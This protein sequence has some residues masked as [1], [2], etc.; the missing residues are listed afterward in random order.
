MTNIGVIILNYIEYGVT[1][2]CVKSFNKQT[3]SNVNV[4]FVIVDNDSPNESYDVLTKKFDK[5]PN[6]TVVK[7][8]E[9][10][11]FANGNNF[12]LREL[13]KIMKPDYV[14][15][16]NSDIILPQDGLYE[17]IIQCYDIYNFGVLG[18]SIYSI[19]GKFYQSPVR[20]LTTDRKKVKRLI[21][22]LFISLIK[23]KLKILFGIEKR[24]N[25]LEKWD[26]SYY[27]RVHDDLTL[28]GAFQ[29]MSKDYFKHY[30][31]AYDPGTFLYLEEDILKVRCSQQNLP[32]IYSPDF[33][34]QHLQSFST[35]SDKSNANKKAYF[36][37]K[38]M[39]KSMIRYKKVLKGE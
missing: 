20:N 3:R 26:N 36:R 13:H 5:I 10:L 31:D 21:F 4:R 28:H 12:G 15:F 1:I 34:V 9:N 19:Y 30:P 37:V 18:P 17:W 11:G 2:D 22:E 7:T 25:H 35:N 16:S 39:L 8:S 23:I 33:T 38:N 32:M 24:S 6:V 14:I 29:V 27:E